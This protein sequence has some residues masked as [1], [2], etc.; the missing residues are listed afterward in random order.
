MK[1][2]SR[3]P[4]LIELLAVILLLSEMRSSHA[5]NLLADPGFESGV[6]SAGGWSPLNAAAFSHDYSHDGVWSLKDAY[7]S[8]GPVVAGTQTVHGIPGATYSLSGWAMTP[9]AL[10]GSL[11]FLMMTFEDS[12]HQLI[13]YNGTV[14]Y[15][16]GTLTSSTP[17]LTWTF[18]S[19][20]VT[21]PPGTAYVEVL[22]ELFN[23]LNPSPNNVVYFDDISL[24]QV[25][26]P[27]GLTIFSVG[28]G[29]FFLRRKSPRH[30]DTALLRR[31][32]PH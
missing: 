23:Q 24:T 14:F 27:V 30:L 22:P 10:S 21:A 1:A 5:Q 13:D 6:F 17:P 15:A 29:L 7:D 18:L 28:L 11:G 2:L 31:G 3:P 32:S 26:E 20:S 8:N 4:H 25:P 16:V 12:N 19:G 9:T